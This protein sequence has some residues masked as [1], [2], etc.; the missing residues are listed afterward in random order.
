MNKVLIS[1]L[2]AITLCLTVNSFGQ[3]SSPIERDV[4]PIDWILVDVTAS[5]DSLWC[6]INR[7]VIYYN[8][9][10]GPFSPWR[11]VFWDYNSPSEYELRWT[12]WVYQGHKHNGVC[13]TSCGTTTCTPTTLYDVECH[14]AFIY[15][16]SSDFMETPT[17][18]EPDECG[19]W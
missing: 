8:A 11:N 6:I 10:Y 3:E 4:P 17:C 18:F 2:L 19:I 5:G 12:S 7:H 15:R 13:T 9:A 16:G 1:A 14:G